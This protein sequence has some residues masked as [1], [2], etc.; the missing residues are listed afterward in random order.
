MEFDNFRVSFTSFTCKATVIIFFFFKIK[1]VTT[2]PSI[3]YNYFMFVGHEIIQ[4][5]V[6]FNLTRR[7]R[8]KGESEK[9]QYNNLML[10]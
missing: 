10:Y 5:N 2:T 3:F 8:E 9:M 6:N 1:Q 4:L 7:Q